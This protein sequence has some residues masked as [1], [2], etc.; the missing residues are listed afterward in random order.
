MKRL[1]HPSAKW[2]IGAVLVTALVTAA[3]IYLTPLKHLN[4]IEPH[5]KEI[6]P[7]AFWAEYQAH[8][9]DYVFVDVRSAGDYAPT[10]PKGAKNIPIQLLYPDNA[11]LPRSGKTIVLTCT[12]GKLSAVAY[13]YL[14]HQGY[15]NLRHIEG[16]LQHWIIEGLPIEGTNLASSTAASTTIHVATSPNHS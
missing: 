2:V 8:P 5:I 1:T 7:A 6:D 16:G 11:K 4:L 9:D 12:G 15:L 10:H 3:V 13:G 14:E